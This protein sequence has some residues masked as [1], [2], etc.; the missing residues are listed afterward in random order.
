MRAGAISETREVGVRPYPFF[1]ESE[2]ARSSQEPGISGVRAP[3]TQFQALGSGQ[4][5]TTG[6]F[7]LLPRLTPLVPDSRFPQ[8]FAQ[9]LQQMSID[10]GMF[11]AAG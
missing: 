9:V 8:E 11:W 7:S 2:A 6:L 5:G 3:R 1:A 4:T 10:S